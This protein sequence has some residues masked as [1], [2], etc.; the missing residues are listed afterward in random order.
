MGSGKTSVGSRLCEKL[1][2]PF[3]DSDREIETQE[4][5]SV[6][7]IFEEK[8]E[9]YFRGL[10]AG[11]CESLSA[12]EPHVISTGG[13]IILSESNRKQ[14]KEN[15]WVFWLDA[16]IA[17]LETRLA[18]DESRPLLHNKP[19]SKTL[20]DILEKRQALYQETAD[21]II[22]T[23][24]KHIDQISMEIYTNFLEKR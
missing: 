24:N 13:G 15:A 5:M 22:H 10:E 1:A 20:S 7:A 17:T 9:A 14:L 4:Q 16:S 23:D 11:F 19:L 18:A 21:Y 8:G 3:L 6:K 2:L 12:L